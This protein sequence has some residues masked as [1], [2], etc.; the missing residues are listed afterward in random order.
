MAGM[1]RDVKRPY[2]KVNRNGYGRPAG[3]QFPA[4]PAVQAAGGAPA[5]AAG[6]LPD[7]MPAASPPRHRRLCD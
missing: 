2:L 5:C 1:I 4:G 3:G 6:D 7:R